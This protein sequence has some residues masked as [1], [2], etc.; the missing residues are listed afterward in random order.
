MT[1][2]E[3]GLAAG[4]P[5]SSADVRIAQY[6]FE[7]RLPKAAISRKI[8]QALGIDEMLLTAPVPTAEEELEVVRFWPEQSL[9]NT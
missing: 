2:Q 7:S 4:F 5:P 9:T 6:E 3:L 1:Q 8:A